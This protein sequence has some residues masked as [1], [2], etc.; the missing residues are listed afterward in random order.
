MSLVWYGR[1]G[2]LLVHL[3]RFDCRE[4]VAK[5]TKKRVEHCDLCRF[6][7]GMLKCSFVSFHILFHRPIL[8]HI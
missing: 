1:R 5:G 2:S 3:P 4:N 8:F 7:F 6:G